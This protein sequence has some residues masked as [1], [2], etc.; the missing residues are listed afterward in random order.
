MPTQLIAKRTQRVPTP[1]RGVT[2]DT[3][4]AVHRRGGNYCVVVTFSDSDTELTSLVTSDKAHA[5]DVAEL[6]EGEGV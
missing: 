1:R 5:L 4:F 3:T 2:V 6:T